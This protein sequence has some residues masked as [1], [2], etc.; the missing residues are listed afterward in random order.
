[1]NTG[2]GKTR[3]KITG[4]LRASQRQAT[5]ADL[6]GK[7]GLPNREVTA[8]LTTMLDEHRG[9]L[10]VTE[11]GEL[12]YY[13]PHGFIN[14]ER[15]I[16]ARLYR[17][18]G[19]LVRAAGR[20][21]KVLF[22][23]WIAVMLVG[24]FVLFSVLLL[25]ALIASIAG[26]TASRNGGRS[27]GRM[28][29]FG[30]FYLTTRILQLLALLFVYRKRGRKRSFN[31]RPLHQSVFAFV[32]GDSQPDKN[33]EKYLRQV[34][35]RYIQANGGLITPDEVMKVTGK[36]HD[37]ALELLNKMLR[38]H[39]GLPEVTDNGTIY[40]VFPKLMLISESVPE[41]SRI[42]SKT[43]L[44]IPFNNNTQKTNRWIGFFN[45]FNLVLGLYFI[46]FSLV[47]TIDVT[48]PIS[49]LY[50]FVYQYAAKLFQP[51]WPL[52]I[53]L[54]LVPV[55]FSI[56][57]FFVPWIRRLFEKRKNNDS[58]RAN[59]R[60]R[61]FQNIYDSPNEVLPRSIIPIGENE[62]PPDWES[63]RQK[64]VDRYAAAK[65]VDIVADTKGGYQYAFGELAREKSD[66]Q[67]VREAVDTDQ[68][69][70]GKTLFD[71]GE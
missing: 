37:Q 18:T 7:T 59:L 52:F 33:W 69:R 22:R 62:I 44:P 48:Q 68:Y 19:A 4:V 27:R 60:K 1:M 63:Y 47:P 61:I 55:A 29:G 49:R 45:G 39:E 66:I 35:I 16:R 67:T 56:L 5:V 26:S 20:T 3:R 13:F 21:L 41:F 12:L 64:T 10:R 54:G 65:D 38:D 34:T 32:F 43:K 42:S 25:A 23:T 46:W 9:H 14:R 53:G 28:G 58:R 40:Y 6:V 71:S 31:G 51:A 15:G 50:V 36:E 2:S 24:Y 8:I 70:L 57:F 30:S 17:T 11:S